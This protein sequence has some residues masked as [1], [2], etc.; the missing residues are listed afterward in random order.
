MKRYAL[1]LKDGEV[2]TM[3]AEWFEVC[4]MLKLYKGGDI[5][6][7]YSIENVVFIV[8]QYIYSDKEIIEQVE[9]KG[10]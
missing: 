10:E 8:E 5:F 7:A 1:K 2:F 6:A 4:E 3:D 9:G